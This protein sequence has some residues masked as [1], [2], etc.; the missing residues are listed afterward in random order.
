MGLLGKIFWVVIIA[1]VAIVLYESWN[2]DSIQFCVN[3]QPKVLDDN[4]VTKTDCVNYM[5]SVYGDYPDTE[6]YHNLLE[7]T[8]SCRSV[9]CSIDDFYVADTCPSGTSTLIYKATIKDK[10]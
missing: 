1:I 5:T 10:V 2:V 6:L 7:E 8:I 4:C 9:N 3:D